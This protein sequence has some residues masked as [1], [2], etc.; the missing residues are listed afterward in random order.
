MA[1]EIVVTL[2]NGDKA[3]ETLKQL[4][5]QAAALKKEISNLKPGTEEFVKSSA[6]LNQVRDRMAD[7]D[8]Q[9]KSTTQSS[10]G[11]KSA[12]GGV[13]NQIPGFSQL[14][15]AL[16]AAQGGVG[17]LTSGFGLL[18]GAIIATGLGAL[19]IVITSLVSWFSKTEEGGNKLSAMFKGVTSTIDVL[20]GRLFNI[21]KTISE[22]FTNPIK[23]F[24]DLGNDML[25]AAKDGYNMVYLFDDIEDRQRDME[26]RAKEADIL[27][28]QL[29]LQAKNVGKT[30]EERIALLDK[31]NDITRKTYEDQL[32]L[33]KEYLDAV[34][35]E[36]AAELKRQGQTEMTGEQA[37]KIKNAKLAYLDLLGQEIQTEE[38]IAN[39]REQIL[40]KQEKAQQKQ[41]KEKQTA[42]EVEAAQAA[43]IAALERANELEQEAAFLQTKKTM[44]DKFDADEKKAEDDLT[45]E[46]IANREREI[47][48][49]EYVQNVRRQAVNAT[50]GTFA[51]AFGTIA[52]FQEQGSADWKAFAT[53]QAALTAIQGGINAYTSTAAIPVVG[54]IL[55][56]IAAATALAAGVLSVSKI[57]ATQMP[58][59]KNSSVRG[60][61]YS[62]GYTGPGGKYVPAGIV[63]AGEVVWSQEDVAMFG[64]VRA[65]EA[66]RPTSPLRGYYSGGPVNPFSNNTGRAPMPSGNA[67]MGGSNGVFD[68]DKMAEA[69]DRRVDNKIKMIRTKVL[70]SD[71]EGGLGT[72]A[73]IRDEANV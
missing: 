18:R 46:K 40:G 53:A 44:N 50:L 31:A 8:K 2:A 29:L 35:K 64:G 30:Y 45:A 15:G 70:I 39:R 49:E 60:E 3:G 9:V 59:A 61:F 43:E 48:Y 1:K 24:K 33:S 55:A 42:A 72:L 73:S 26:V 14:S 68:Y 66:M 5:H 20:L 65:V 4:T 19:V 23:F 27:V 52:S 21:R 62:G 10:N 47:E 22:F 57:Q 7:I 69:F 58:R 37:D 51:N 63:H 6:S 41:T 17:G 36:V 16:S 25:D 38:K 67:G 54:P 32:A 28:D 34:E 13:L 11:F 71:I 56:P 12:L